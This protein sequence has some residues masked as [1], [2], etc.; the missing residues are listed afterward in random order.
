MTRPASNSK[1]IDLDQVG[2]W[3]DV[4]EE[5]DIRISA[6]LNAIRSRIPADTYEHALY[7]LALE[8]SEDE[9]LWTKLR[10]ELGIPKSETH[11]GQ[12]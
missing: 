5:R 2:L 8:I 1:L 12:A 11:G 4:L 10:E 6:L 9:T 3:L 7:G